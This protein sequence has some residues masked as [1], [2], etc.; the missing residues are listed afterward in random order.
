MN[1]FIFQSLPERFDLREKLEPGEKDTWYATRYRSKMKVGDIV[2]FWMAGDKRFKGI[3]GYGKITSEPY[4]KNDWKTYGVD[5]E[6]VEKYDKPLTVSKLKEDS[7]LSKLLI[8]RA[9][10]ATN[11]L[12]EP[13]ELKKLNRLL[14]NFGYRTPKIEDDGR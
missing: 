5:I 3:Y 9:P 6:Y 12:V 7:V 1:T 4:I 2:F 14:K 10:Q 13:I 8:F 11:F